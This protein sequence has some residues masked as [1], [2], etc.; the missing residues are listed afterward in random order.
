MNNIG[1]IWKSWQK[2]QSLRTQQA[3]TTWQAL[4]ATWWTHITTQALRHDE[5]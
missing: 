5:H 3:F 1:G 4:V 2:Q